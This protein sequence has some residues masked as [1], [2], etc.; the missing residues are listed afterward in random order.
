MHTRLLTLLL[1][2]ALGVPTGLRAQEPVVRIS[3]AG[4]S[5]LWRL[6]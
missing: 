1:L 5:S 6:A 2:G 3:G 4:L